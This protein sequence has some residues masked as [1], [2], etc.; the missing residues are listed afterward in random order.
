MNC[1]FCGIKIDEKQH[2]FIHD[3]LICVGCTH[4]YT[5]DEI[6]DKIIKHYLDRCNP[7]MDTSIS[8]DIN[9]II[10]GKTNEDN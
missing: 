9:I 10:G 4:E 8:D 1:F 5:D 2:D 6:K 7:V 3:E